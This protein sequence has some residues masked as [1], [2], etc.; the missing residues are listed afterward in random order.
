MR[1]SSTPPSSRS[2]HEYSALPGTV[3]LVDVVGE[4]E[5]QEVARAG[6]FEVDDAHVRH[7]EHAGVAAHRVV[8]LDLRAVV[9]RHV[10]AAEVDHAGARGAVRGV[11]DGGFEHG[12]SRSERKRTKRQHRLAPS[13]LL[14]ERLPE[15]PADAGTSGCPFGGPLAACRRAAALQMRVA[16]AQSFCLSG[17]GITPSAAPRRRARSPARADEGYRWGA[18]VSKPRCPPPRL[19]RACRGAPTKSRPR[20]PRGRLSASKQPLTSRASGCTRP[21]S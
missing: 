6:A 20:L 21:S 14:P 12:F 8:L 15:S 17:F 1:S 4:R 11:E 16:L 13:V 7:V 3:Q 2:R 10:P 9:D 19:R 18:P 5:A